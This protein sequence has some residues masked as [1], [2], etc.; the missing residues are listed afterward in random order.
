MYYEF[1]GGKTEESWTKIWKSSHPVGVMCFIRVSYWGKTQLRFVEPKAKINQEYYFDKLLTPLFESDIPEMFAGRKY[2]PLFHHDNAP[3][4]SGKKTQA[5]LENSEFDYIPWQDWLGNSPNMSLVD[6][7]VNG[8]F[9]QNLFG[10][11]PTTLE[12]QKR[13]AIEAWHEV[14]LAIIQKAFRYGRIQTMLKCQD[15]HVER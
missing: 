7:C 12:G 9:K 1:K 14:D 3:A 11:H 5:Y 6:F 2:K 10:R 15:Y 4:H 8:I 13:V